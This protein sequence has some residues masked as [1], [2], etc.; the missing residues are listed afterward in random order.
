MVHVMG[1]HLE[2]DADAQYTVAVRILRRIS[3][4][5]LNEYLYISKVNGVVLTIH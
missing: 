5:F 4:V 2:K 3:R 1:Y